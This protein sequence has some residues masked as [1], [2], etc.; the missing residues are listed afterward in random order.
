[1]LVDGLLQAQ[2][3]LL[4][5]TRPIPEGRGQPGT[6]NTAVRSRVKQ[7]DA[8][9]VFGDG[10]AMGAGKALDGAAQAQAS[11]VMLPEDSWLGTSPGGEPQAP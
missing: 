11:Q 2:E 4:D 6:H 7:G 5:R 8:Q 1:M 3:R 10:V 9:A